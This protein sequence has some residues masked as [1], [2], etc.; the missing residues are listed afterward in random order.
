MVALLLPHSGSTKH[1]NEGI[2]LQHQ[3][4]HHPDEHF[5]DRRQPL[6]PAHV[7]RP[8]G[9]PTAWRATRCPAAGANAPGP[10]FVLAGLHGRAGVWRGA[11]VAAG[12]VASPGAGRPDRA[13]PGD[14]GAV[15]AVLAVGGPA[16]LASGPAMAGAAA[17]ARG[18]NA[19]GGFGLGGA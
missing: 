11:D 17:L 12:P 1:A 19:H 7:G 9:A 13:D 10:V 2:L 6:A 8:V 15:C 14:R 18:A 16:Q 3:P 4:K 5:A